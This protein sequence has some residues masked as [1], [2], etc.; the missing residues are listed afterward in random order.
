MRGRCSRNGFVLST[1]TAASEGQILQ[2]SV[3][4]ENWIGSYRWTPFSTGKRAPRTP[5]KSL[6]IIFFLYIL[7]AVCGL[8]RFENVDKIQELAENKETHRR[9][10]SS[11]RSR[12]LFVRAKKE[13]KPMRF[14][15][16][17]QLPFTR[18]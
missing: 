2:F 10:F 15:F 11:G 12:R 13:S 14:K 7:R 16:D 18:I 9:F 17:T 1:Y 4:G 3:K 5:M 8:Q 6:F